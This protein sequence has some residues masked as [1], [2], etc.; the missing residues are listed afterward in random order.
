M[1]TSNGN[2]PAI[3]H[4]PVEEVD[5]IMLQRISQLETPNKVLAVV[6]KKNFPPLQL[7]TTLPW[8]SM[9]YRIPAI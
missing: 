9:A 7:S 8:H 2:H 4:I 5:E 3:A 6:E 1:L